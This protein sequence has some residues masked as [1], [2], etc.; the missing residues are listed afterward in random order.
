M[1]KP[2]VIDLSEEGSEV[3]GEGGIWWGQYKQ[4]TM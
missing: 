1:M 4:S 2:L 3:A